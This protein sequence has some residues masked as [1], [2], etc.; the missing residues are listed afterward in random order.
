MKL[1]VVGNGFVGNALVAAMEGSDNITV[2]A[3]DLNT[4]LCVPKG[5]TLNDLMDADAIFVSV[6]TPMNEDGSCCTKIVE[7]A[8]SQIRELNYAG[9]IVLRSTVPPGTSKRLGCLFM[10]EFLTE[11]KPLDDFINNDN[12]VFGVSTKEEESFLKEMIN[13]AQDDGCIKSNTCSFV[14]TS[15]GEMIK[16]FRNVF[17]AMKVSICNELENWCVQESINYDNVRKVAFSDKRIGLSHTM[18]PGPD[19]HRGFGGTCFPKDVA[20]SVSSMKRSVVIAAGQERNNTI[21][22]PE[23]DW[24]EDKGRAVV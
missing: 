3:Y 22:R 9:L 21:D 17:L 15:E 14:T 7:I 13:I 4:E 23:Q 2:L 12:W 16:M 18:V 8:I 19:N 11:A 24:C 10:P 1:G 20:S 5:T 6:P